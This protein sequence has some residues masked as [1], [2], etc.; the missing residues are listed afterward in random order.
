MTHELKTPIAIAYSANDA[1]LH[2][3][4]ANDPEK[5]ETYLRIANR[6]LKRLGELVEGILAVSMERRKTMRLSMERILLLPLVQDVA[7]VQGT[8]MEKT[9]P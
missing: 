5:R 8:R 9:S 7:A 1:L 4:T 3:D 2:F 6:Q